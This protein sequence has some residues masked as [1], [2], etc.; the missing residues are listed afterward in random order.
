METGQPVS[1][2]ADLRRYIDDAGRSFEY[3][4][5]RH[6]GA[7]AL[8]IHLSAFFGRWGEARQ[9]RETFG[10]YFH[11]L[12]MLGGCEDYD[13]LFL[14]DAYGAFSNGTYYTG[15]RGDLFVER[16]VIAISTEVMEELGHPPQR[17]VAIGS[18]MGATGALV[19]GLRLHLAG[20]VAVSPHVN[21]DVAAECCGRWAEVAYACPDGDPSSPSSRPV[22]RRV[23]TLLAERTSP[24]PRLFVQTCEDDTG[25]YQ[26]QV[27][28]LVD[29][30]RA[31]GGRVDVDLRPVGGHTSDFATRA[32]LLDVVD[33]IL[34]GGEVDV[35]RYA[36]DP[37]F[38][39][40]P[41]R[42]PLWSR[43]RRR[44]ALRSRLRRWRRD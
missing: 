10:G 7:A 5:V 33:R 26:E 28:P 18:S 16:A 4:V 17:T 1:E 3:A 25:V 43:L 14:C 44:V 21:L 42:E 35:P 19:L 37:A 13:W 6:R 24:P 41:R 30:W 40:P 38:A 11:R 22:T 23:Q 31:A 36:T 8:G 20:V 9:Y 15:H 2:L 29:G 34:A 32:V 12:R 27:L 39:P